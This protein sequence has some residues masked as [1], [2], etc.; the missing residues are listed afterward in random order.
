M[1]S[2]SLSKRMLFYLQNQYLSRKHV[3]L[4]L[5]LQQMQR[6]VLLMCMELSCHGSSSTVAEK[7]TLYTMH[8]IV[9]LNFRKNMG[10]MILEDCGSLFS[11]FLYSHSDYRSIITGGELAQRESSRFTCGGSSVRSRY[12][13]LHDALDGLFSLIWNN[14][15][16]RLYSYYHKYV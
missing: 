4:I 15:T 16:T 14:S 6:A 7:K 13:P 2:D 1:N 3:L 10:L 5:A 11:V 8:C 9:Y 12:S